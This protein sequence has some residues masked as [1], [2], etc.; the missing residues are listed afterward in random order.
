MA[1]FHRYLIVLVS[2]T[3]LLP[4]LVR[5]QAGAAAAPAEIEMKFTVFAP[6]AV[7]GMGYFPDGNRKPLSNVKFYNSYRSPVYSYK[8]G[9]VVRFYDEAEV[10]VVQAA[11][12][13]G[14]PAPVLNPIAVCAIPE[15]VTTAFLLFIPRSGAAI[16]GFKFD[17]FVM[18]DGEAS[19]PLE[20]FV[21][22]NASKMELLARINGNDTKILRGVSP[23][24]KADKG[25][26]ILMAARTEPEYH[27]L[28]I[29]DTWDLGPRQR[30]LVIFF[31]PRT[32]TALLPDVV[33]IND[34][35]PE[36]KKK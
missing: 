17:I 12:A 10:A 3:G 35:M 14:R 32:A 25:L 30:N 23:P 26:V 28:L 22:I 31:P 1:Y 36:E 4:N 24:I 20:H 8:G 27:K 11:V 19:V 34:Q 16:G 13:A 33:R 18:D 6:R 2:L 9:A 21:I 29:A 15:G 5:G 7:K